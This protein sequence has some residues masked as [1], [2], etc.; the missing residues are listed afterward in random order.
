MP[1]VC[2]PPGV[3]LG[4]ILSTVAFVPRVYR[5][6]QNGFRGR[7]ASIVIG[8]NLTLLANVVPFALFVGQTT[9]E[10]NYSRFCDD[11]SRCRAIGQQ[12]RAIE[13]EI[14]L[15]SMFPFG[16]CYLSYELGVCSTADTVTPSERPL[17]E[18]LAVSI[19]FY[20]MNFYVALP[21]MLVCSGLVWWH[22]RRKR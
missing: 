1:F 13:V 8:M 10:G 5:L 4:I 15:R 11:L 17:V 9:L 16:Q 3:F 2:F 14:A 12:E 22:T 18:R 7:A 21:G 19:N 6:S 20:K